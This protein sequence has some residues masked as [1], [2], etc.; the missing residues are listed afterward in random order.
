MV[1]HAYAIDEQLIGKLLLR[2][3]GS[4]RRSF[5]P[6]RPSLVL[7]VGQA[8]DGP[9]TVH[10]AEHAAEAIVEGVLALERLGAC[11]VGEVSA[12]FL[13]HGA[14]GLVDIAHDGIQAHE[15]DGNLACRFRH[16][17]S[18]AVG[19]AADMLQTSAFVI[20]MRIQADSGFDLVGLEPAVFGGL[21]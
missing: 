15:P 19:D 11:S 21:F 12:A 2:Y 9:D 13:G 16:I 17:G 3:V 18:D 7:R 8:D 1:L 6:A 5:L 4:A 10:G 14:T 20:G